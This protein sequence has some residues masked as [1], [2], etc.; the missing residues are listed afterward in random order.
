MYMYMYVSC[1]YYKQV[2]LIAMFHIA[3]GTR[4]PQQHFHSKYV[5]FQD[6]RLRQLLSCMNRGGGVANMVWRRPGVMRPTRHTTSEPC[7]SDT[8]QESLRIIS[9]TW[10]WKPSLQTL[11]GNWR[12]PLDQ[13]SFWRGCFVSVERHTLT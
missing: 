1:S 8:A 13:S 12:E 11:R 3:T 4:S 9:D 2:G 7:V 6:R 10:S 5:F